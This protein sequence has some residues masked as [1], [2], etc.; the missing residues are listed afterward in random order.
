MMAGITAAK[1]TV[2]LLIDLRTCTRELENMPQCKTE[3]RLRKTERI[4]NNNA[5][6]YA[7]RKMNGLEAQHMRCEAGGR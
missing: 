2:F 3:S 1:S 7:L 6:K 5:P 4:K